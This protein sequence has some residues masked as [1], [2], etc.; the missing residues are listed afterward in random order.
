M[1]R[2]P[3][4]SGCQPAAVAERLHSAA[5]HLL[6]RLR[7]S[8]DAAGISPARLSALSV[9]VFAGPL[10]M[11]QLASAEQVT[12]P[13][14]TRL[15][16]ALQRDGLVAREND[17]TDGRVTWIRATAKGSRLL[18]EARRRRVAALTEDLGALKPPDLAALA[19]AAAIMERL[20][21]ARTEEPA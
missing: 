2:K 14:M 10:T 15:V 1:A 3:A 19:R 20:G 17:E 5:I 7:A 13:T 16:A 21:G 6:R 8:D 11:G 12:A 4:A 18:R 9:A